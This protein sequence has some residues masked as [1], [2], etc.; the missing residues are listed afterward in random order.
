MLAFEVWARYIS[1]VHAIHRCKVF[2]G[3]VPFADSPPTTVA[4]QVLSGERPKRPM[5]PSLTDKVWRAIQYCWTQEPSL[6]PEIQEVLS[7]LRCASKSPQHLTD[8]TFPCEVSE[9]PCRGTSWLLRLFSRFRGSRFEAS[10]PAPNTYDIKI[11]FCD[12]SSSVD[13]WGK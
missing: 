4:V 13:S 9:R 7:K 5:H 3:A 11:D 6:R 12:S 8:E 10:P 1:A 2:A